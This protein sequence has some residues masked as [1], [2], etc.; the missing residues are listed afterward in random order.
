MKEFKKSGKLTAEEPV[1]TENG[2]SVFSQNGGKNI[3]EIFSN[4]ITEEDGAYIALLAFIDPDEKIQKE[5]SALKKVLSKKF[6]AVVT[7]GFGPRFL[8]STGQLHKG[9]GNKGYFIQITSEITD[10]LEVPNQG[11]SFGTLITAQAQGDLKALTNLGRRVIRFHITG[12]VSEGIKK[13]TEMI[14]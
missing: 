1:S 4:F 12:N 6:N 10:D 7:S 14:K 3:G 5:L 11:Y 9:D 2:I 13:L 8:H